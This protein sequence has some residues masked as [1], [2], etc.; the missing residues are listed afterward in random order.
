MASSYGRYRQ[1]LCESKLRRLSKVHTNLYTPNGVGVQI[2]IYTFLVV[3]WKHGNCCTE[4][5]ADCAQ[6]QSPDQS[7]FVNREQHPLG[8]PSQGELS[9][10]A[11]LRGRFYERF[12]MFSDLS[13]ASGPPPLRKGRQG[14]SDLS[15]LQILINCSVINTHTKT[16]QYELL[17]FF[18]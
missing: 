15:A 2:R 12:R 14:C 9:S 10:A 4:E 1:P 11:R 5:N 3:S 16:Q 17:C 6:L 18:L 8:S 13:T 7:E